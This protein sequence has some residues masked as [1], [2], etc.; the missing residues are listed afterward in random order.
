MEEVSNQSCTKMDEQH[1]ELIDI[2]PNLLHMLCTIVNEVRIAVGQA[3]YSTMLR[4]QDGP[5]EER[6]VETSSTTPQTKIPVV[7]QAIDLGM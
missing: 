7:A 1:I 6:P 3:P 2:I 4:D 5:S